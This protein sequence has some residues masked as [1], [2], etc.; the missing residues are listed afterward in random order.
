VVRVWTISA[1][2]GVDGRSIA[3][4][5][6]QTLDIPMLDRQALL[7]L[8]GESG[9][10]EDMDARVTSRLQRLGLE[11]A[12][13]FGAAQAAQELSFL[14]QLAER[15][16]KLMGRLGHTRCVILAPAA[17]GAIDETESALHT[18]VWAP[19]DWRVDR[20]ARERML[21]A[22]EARDRVR[23][24]DRTQRQFASRLFNLDLDD[25]HRFSLVVNAREVGREPAV[26]AILAAGGAPQPETVQI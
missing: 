1:A 17:V 26:R 5:L 22:H 23:E 2:A 3:T 14:T 21:N 25:P 15:G 11:Y 6:A 24:L 10:T 12:A 19:I 18:R 8:F 13:W 16:R 9:T 20:L 4:A 7:K